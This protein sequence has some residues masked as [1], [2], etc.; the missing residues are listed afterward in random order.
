MARFDWLKDPVKATAA[1]LLVALIGVLVAILS[2]T[3]DLFDGGEVLS[4]IP[5]TTT[6][7]TALE[8][9]A[10]AVSRASSLP[11]SPS[12]APPSSDG[13]HSASPGPTSSSTDQPS[14]VTYLDEL[15]ADQ[16]NG[17]YVREP[18]TMNHILYDRSVQ[19]TCN[20]KDSWFIYPIAG[21]RTLSFALGIDDSVTSAF[22]RAADVTFYAD[23]G[24]QIGERHTAG[25]GAAQKVEV[26]VT[27]V[28][29]LKI[30]CIG[31]DAESNEQK[32][33]P[34][35]ALGEAVLTR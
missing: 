10:P 14:G 30:R 26:D 12:A 11:T 29:Q 6:S 19:L 9:P 22:G 32:N 15:S 8:T 3:N 25:L 34:H 28:I 1:G 23:R 33:V 20:G 27:G 35:V 16:R 4:S 5:E 21:H 31:R 13:S 18:V 24:T 17:G 2:L 7:S